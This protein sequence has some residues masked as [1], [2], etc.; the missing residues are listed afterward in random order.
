MDNTTRYMA[1]L[2]IG[3]IV[4]GISLFVL[5]IPVRTVIIFFIIGF[6][7]VLLWLYVDTKSKQQTTLSTITKQVCIC[8][9]CKH[10]E[11]KLCLE[12]R[13]ACCI[14]M[15]GNSVIGHSINPLQ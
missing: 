4:F 11:A 7:L 15:K 5:H 8:Q 9:I 12:R 13:C 6:P 10:E 3:T 14:M 1:M 2:G